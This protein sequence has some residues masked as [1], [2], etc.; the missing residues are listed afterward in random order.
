VSGQRLG[1]AIAGCAGF[2]GRR[3]TFSGRWDAFGWSDGFEGLEPCDFGGNFVGPGPSSG[4]G[5]LQAPP[6]VE[7]APGGEDPQP[8]P[9]CSLRRVAR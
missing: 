6:A 2:H 5:E 3:V 9:L 8:E 4:E 1:P 7:G